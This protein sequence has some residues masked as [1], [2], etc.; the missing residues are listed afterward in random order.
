MSFGITNFERL[1]WYIQVALEDME[2]QFQA[3]LRHGHNADGSHTTTN[4][5][6]NFESEGHWWRRGPWI[7]DDPRA[8]D[9][10]VAGLRPPNTPAGTYHNFAPQGIDSCVILEIEGTGPI[11][12]TGLKARLGFH[13]RLL[14]LRNRDSIHPVTLK[15]EN[16]GSFRTNWF[17]LPGDMDVVLAPNQNIWLY[18]DRGR[19]A[20]TAAI[21]PCQF[22]G[23]GPAL[24]AGQRMMELWLLDNTG[25]PTAL[26]MI[27]WS[28][29][30]LG[31]SSGGPTAPTDSQYVYLLTT[32]AVPSYG[33][34]IANPQPTQLS[35]GP[36]TWRALVQTDATNQTAHR[37]WAGLANFP[38]GVFATNSD[39]IGVQAVMFRWNK[40]GASSAANGNWFIVASD[41]A[42]QTEA[43]TGVAVI[44]GASV[45][46]HPYKLTIVV[47]TAYAVSW[48]IEDVTAGTTTSG[49]LTMPGT[50]N[51]TT[52][53]TALISLTELAIGVKVFN[54]GRMSLLTN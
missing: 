19:N 31:T 45:T 53:M 3:W 37:V 44:G 4:G 22:G 11:I 7:F 30:G 18:Y 15:H 24:G 33:Y 28:I 46:P 2:A 10:H 49:A 51:A 43:D 32:G 42:T 41:G 34:Y 16:T 6:N 40:T 1:P 14:M 25:G 38:G 17:N 54:V 50:P 20:W 29:T 27:G 52:R 8:L 13:K 36:L 5:V 39:T 23:I 48:T 12:L 35:Y 26:A 21:T 9:N 47:T